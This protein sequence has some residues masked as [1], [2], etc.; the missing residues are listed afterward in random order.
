MLFRSGVLGL[1]LLDPLELVDRHARVL[2]LP[3]VVRRRADAVFAADLCHRQACLSLAQDRQ[4]LGL[5]ELRLPHR[6]L[7]RRC[8]SLYFQLVYSMG[9]LTSRFV[10]CRSPSTR[11]L[12]SDRLNI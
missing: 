10:K 6:C 5:R 7:P 1:E 4:N 9:E 2:A 3:L 12:I 8:G 11:V